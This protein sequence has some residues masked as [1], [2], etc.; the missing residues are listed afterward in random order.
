MQRLIWTTDGGESYTIRDERNM[1]HFVDRDEVN[2]YATPREIRHAKW[3]HDQ[4]NYD[5]PGYDS[6]TGM[7]FWPDVPDQLWS[8]E[9]MGDD[10]ILIFNF[11]QTDVERILESSRLMAKLGIHD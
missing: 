4:F 9:D 8:V 2:N 7:Y 11:S 1:Y 10:L 6:E 5:L 3:L